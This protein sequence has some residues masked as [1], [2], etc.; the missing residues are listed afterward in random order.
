MVSEK[1]DQ[2][3]KWW[4]NMIKEQYISEG[5]GK[6]EAICLQLT[7]TDEKEEMERHVMQE[8][9]QDR[10]LEQIRH[11][12]NLITSNKTLAAYK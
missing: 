3:R 5:E 1:G 2:R 12:F 10:A 11:L 7:C 9:E 8:K 4:A 6:M